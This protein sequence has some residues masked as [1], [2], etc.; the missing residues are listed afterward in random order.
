MANHKEV[1]VFDNH[2][3]SLLGRAGALLLC[4]STLAI[5]GDTACIFSVN[6]AK[7]SIKVDQN[8]VY[9]GQLI[10][11]GK[12]KANA[13]INPITLDG[14]NTTAAAVP[15]VNGA[16]YSLSATDAKSLMRL[17]VIANGVGVAS[18]NIDGT[19][20]TLVLGSVLSDYAKKVT[21]DKS[22]KII[23]FTD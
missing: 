16:K 2:Y 21:L 5:A 1:T 19:K 13:V 20:N 7:Y 11:T 3:R 18:V 17:S 22:A 4:A 6:S 15:L 8:N 9:G 10:L 12:G 23:T 14:R